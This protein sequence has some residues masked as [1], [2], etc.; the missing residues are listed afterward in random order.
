MNDQKK[1]NHEPATG[2]VYK[3]GLLRGLALSVACFEPGEPMPA[4]L[5]KIANIIV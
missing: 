5:I 2:N 1:A 4:E 3:V